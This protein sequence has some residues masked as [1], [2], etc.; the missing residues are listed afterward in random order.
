MKYIQDEL[1]KIS[2]L[3][4]A[5]D[6]KG[7]SGDL[8]KLRDFGDWLKHHGEEISY[9]ASNARKAIDKDED[10]FSSNKVENIGD[11]IKNARKTLNDLEK[12]YKK[13]KSRKL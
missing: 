10:S 8:S 4:I 3:L 11:D 7:I 13:L 2:K 12:V 5:I 6:A 9:L 1:N